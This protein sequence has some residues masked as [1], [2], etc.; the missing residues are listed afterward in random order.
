MKIVKLSILACVISAFSL[1]AQE[2]SPRTLVTNC[3]NFKNN[4]NQVFRS[5]S[6]LPLKLANSGF[7]YQN[8]EKGFK[9][10]CSDA[11]FY[12]EQQGLNSTKNN[13]R[14]VFVW[15]NQKDFEDPTLTIDDVKFTENK[16]SN[17]QHWLKSTD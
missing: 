7:Y 6:E 5:G 10:V 13:Q 17:I 1:N 8:F 4:I 2:A 9:G 15:S 3:L 12:L 16:P 14:Y 11:Q